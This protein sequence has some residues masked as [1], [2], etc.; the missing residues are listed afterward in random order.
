MTKQTL[1][2]LYNVAWL[3]TEENRAKNL[4][5]LNILTNC[6]RSLHITIMLKKINILTDCHCTLQITILLKTNKQTK[7]IRHVN[8]L[9]SLYTE[10]N[11]FVIFFLWVNFYISSTYTILSNM[12][13]LRFSTMLITKISFKFVREKYFSMVGG[14]YAES[15]S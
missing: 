6:H 10:D 2:K 4:A 9:E 7:R 11:N 1:K 12:T 15:H 14:A 5:K 8:Q 13:T 3:S